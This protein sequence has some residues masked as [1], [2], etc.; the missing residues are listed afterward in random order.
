MFVILALVGA[1]R[2]QDRPKGQEPGAKKRPQDEQ[3]PTGRVEI[4]YENGLIWQDGDRTALF[5]TGGVTVRRGDMELKAGR[6]V[7]WS[8]KGAGESYE[9]I[10]LEGNVVI[11]RDKRKLHCER[12]YF[13]VTNPDDP[14]AMI[15]EFRGEAYS[16]QFKEVFYVRAREARM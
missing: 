8:R 5:C 4:S 6:A 12:L 2:A 14:K 3:L 13:D 1:A 10:Y 7:I 9:E 11:T 15:I 16:R